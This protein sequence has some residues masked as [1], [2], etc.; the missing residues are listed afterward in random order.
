M[1][2]QEK[3]AFLGPV[4]WFLYA[5]LPI[6]GSLHML[7][8]FKT[9]EAHVVWAVTWYCWRAIHEHKI[10]DTD[11]LVW[12]IGSFFSWVLKVYLLHKNSSAILLFTD[13][14]SRGP[15]VEF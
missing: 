7:T 3:Y 4:K 10:D 8:Y 6:L 14:I 9:L 15:L 11:E 13:V 12:E 5:H 2:C 1:L